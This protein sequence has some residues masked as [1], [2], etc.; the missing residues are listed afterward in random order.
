MCPQK[1]CPCLDSEPLL[2]EGMRNTQ[3][4]KTYL[5]LDM[6]SKWILKMNTSNRKR[7]RSMSNKC[8]ILNL[9]IPNGISEVI[10]FHECFK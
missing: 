3:Q 8:G 7:N 10:I 5:V 9:T 2:L 4:E 6:L 1:N